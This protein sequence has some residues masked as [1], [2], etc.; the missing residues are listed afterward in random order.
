MPVKRRRWERFTTEP[1]DILLQKASPVPSFDHY[2][3]QQIEQF[4]VVMLTELTV[5]SQVSQNKTRQI[6]DVFV[7]PSLSLYFP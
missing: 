2:G 4:A 1:V 3:K 7:Y 5:L 6:N